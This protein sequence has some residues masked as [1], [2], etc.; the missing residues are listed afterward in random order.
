MDE[1]TAPQFDPI[2]HS[3]GG[4]PR[5]RP[6]EQR[7]EFVGF[8]LTAD[9][10]ARLDEAAAA[11]HAIS[12]GD[13]LRAVALAEQDGAT[14]TQLPKH[15]RRRDVAPVVAQLGR[16]G[17]LLHQYI[18]EARFGPFTPA[19]EAAAQETIKALGDYLRKLATD[20]GDD[21]ET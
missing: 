21:P 19:T 7:G 20:A 16:L 15:K 2:R 11:A 5:K 12:R 1:A 6:E 8:W 17:G 14:T 10:L 3:R 18:K 9:E 13:Y 4:R